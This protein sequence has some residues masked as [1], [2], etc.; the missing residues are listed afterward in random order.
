MHPQPQHRKKEDDIEV[1]PPE[2]DYNACS[3]AMDAI[4]IGSPLALLEILSAIYPP[5]LDLIFDQHNAGMLWQKALNQR[6]LN[7]LCGL[8][9]MPNYE[10]I[11]TLAIYGFSYP[12]IENKV[13]KAFQPG[14][15]G[16]NHPKDTLIERVT[17]SVSNPILR[18]RIENGLEEGQPL[19]KILRYNGNGQAKKNNEWENSVRNTLNP[20]DFSSRYKK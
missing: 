16:L 5:H 17:E 20:P 12:A 8:N 7:G 19:L 9:P 18:E 3:R 15:F 14:F 6:Q 2:I 10:V 1:V 4:D 11:S 13:L